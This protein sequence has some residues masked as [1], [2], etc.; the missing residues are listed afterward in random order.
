[1]PTQKFVL[2]SMMETE[3]TFDIPGPFTMRA[4]QFIRIIIDNGV[5]DESITEALDVYESSHVL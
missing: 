4:A 1:M 3:N 2:R 5:C